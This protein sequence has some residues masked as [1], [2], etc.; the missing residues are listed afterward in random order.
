MLPSLTLADFE[1][2]FHDRHLIHGVVEK[3]SRETPSA[4]AL[5]DADREQRISWAAFDR[6]ATGVALSLLRAG[7]RKGDCF[8][9]VLP[10]T[11]EHLFLEYACFKVGVVFV[12]LDLRLGPA[13]LL[14]SLNLVDAVGFAFVK[15][16]AVPDPAGLGKQLE[17]LRLKKLVQFAPPADCIE[18]SESISALLQESV[19]L[20]TPGADELKS[21]YAAYDV[22]AA[23]V[24]E[25]DGA[26]V[27]FTTGSTG[28]PKP[29]LLSHRN[30]ACQA[31]CISRL[32]RSDKPL[33]TL[34]NLPASHVGCQT[35]LLMG[36]LFEG[37]T[38]V[39]LPIFDPGQ[40]MR[41]ISKFGVSAIGQIPAMFQFEWRLKDYDSFDL[42]NL[43][44]AAYGGQQVS[45]EFIDK[46]ATMATSVGTGLGL[47]EAAGF[48]TYIRRDRAQA[49]EC[50]SSLGNSMPVY[51]ATIRAAMCAD[52]TAGNELPAG[53]LGH[54]C[55]RGPQTFLG[56]LNDPIATASA[57]SRDGYLYTGDMGFQDAEGLHLAGR[58][59]LVIKPAGYQVFPGDVEK[60]FS[61]LP[62]VASCA[63]VGVEH[64]VISEAIVAFIELKP[65]AQLTTLLL[66]KH[67]RELATYM[68]PRHYVLLSPGE[69]PLNR[70]AKAD[71]L[72]LR[73]RA[74]R[75]VE[76]LKAKGSWS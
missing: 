68:R 37:G 21:L 1:E 50:V 4:I 65:E 71:Y 63:V 49:R 11:S 51:P 36:T 3:W 58:A 18:G 66:E 61:K 46:M 27:I 52:G 15:S 64:P 39:L 32:L 9:T 35:E 48:C 59:K 5:I 25:N 31:M 45:T 29:A 7:L 14:R 76:P 22:A 12:P 47:T 54:V 28:S 23:D 60:H 13:E 67:A 34:V 44:F 69:M 33:V 53:E 57:I 56:Y 38:A 2:L 55:F 26:L 70:V 17:S 20:S 72:V 10:L 62:E 42:R 8:A 30:V 41:A 73:E 24:S 74:Q 43:D 40:S 19:K 6:M 16:P 75:E